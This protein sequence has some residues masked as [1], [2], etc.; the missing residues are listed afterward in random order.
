MIKTL[1]IL[2]FGFLLGAC[3]SSDFSGSSQTKKPA[4]PTQKSE[5]QTQKITGGESS[6]GQQSS[7]PV[8]S[9]LDNQ[10]I[11][12]GPSEGEWNDGFIDSAPGDAINIGSFKIWTVPNDPLPLQPYQV[13][14]EVTFPAPLQN[15]SRSDL[16]GEIEGTEGW[17]YFQLGSSQYRPAEFEVQG[18]QAR[19]MTWIPGDNAEQSYGDIITVHSKQLNETQSVEVQF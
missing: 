4:E 9:D 14:V 16:S 7:D 13:V 18:H 17:F 12:D 11:P 10:L 19:L 1:T 2:L 6:D 5:K 15:Y 8:E 3:G